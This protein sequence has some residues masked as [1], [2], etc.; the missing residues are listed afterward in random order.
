MGKGMDEVRSRERTGPPAAQGGLTGML[1]LS[2]R[3]NNV[4]AAS[5]RGGSG[6]PTQLGLGEA[7][8]KT[9][10]DAIQEELARMARTLATWLGHVEA[11]SR[12]RT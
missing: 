9:G 10:L 8:V 7:G 6:M 3:K 11:E 12:H 4:D 2:R 1:E 5:L